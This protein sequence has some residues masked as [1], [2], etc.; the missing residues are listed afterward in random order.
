MDEIKADVQGIRMIKKNGKPQLVLIA[1]NE[2]WADI[3]RH[4]LGKAVYLKY[5]YDGND[6]TFYLVF[7]LPDINKTFKVQVN[8][9]PETRKWLNLIDNH[10]VTSIRTA[11]RDGKGGTV[12]YGD[13]VSITL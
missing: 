11:Y 1:L 5:L 12:L 9:T 3:L 7:D 8:A 4:T 10:K 13:P 6:I 2:L